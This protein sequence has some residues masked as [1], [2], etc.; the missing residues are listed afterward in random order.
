VVVV[1]VLIRAL[2]R[3]ILRRQPGASAKSSRRESSI[4]K[5]ASI[6]FVHRC[7]FNPDISSEEKRNRVRDPVKQGCNETTNR[8]WRWHSL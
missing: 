8:R 5:I 6:N 4:A 1:V 3:I 7:A 2:R